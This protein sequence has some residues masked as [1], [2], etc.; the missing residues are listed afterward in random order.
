MSKYSVTVLLNWLP[1]CTDFDQEF[2]P[3]PIPHQDRPHMCQE[4]EVNT[5]IYFRLSHILKSH[6][7]AFICSFCFYYKKFN[8]T[9]WIFLEANSESTFHS[10]PQRCDS[11]KKSWRLYA[12]LKDKEL[13]CFLFI[14]K[15][16]WK[17]MCKPPIF[18][19]I[20]Y[21]IKV[22]A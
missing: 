13:H 7:L 22:V 20:F 5:N 6:S 18:S 10:G 16:N 11:E 3:Q 2:V 4:K 15:N 19:H 14:V 1:S 17:N 21:F 9:I 8:S 12:I